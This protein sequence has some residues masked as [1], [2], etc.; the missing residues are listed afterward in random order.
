MKLFKKLYYRAAFAWLFLVKK[1]QQNKDIDNKAGLITLNSLSNAQ[2]QHIPKIIWMYWEGSQSGLLK[3][4]I[5]RIRDLHP[6]YQ[7]YL[8]DPENVKE[9]SQLDFSDPIIE[10]ATPQQRADLIRFDL[11]YRYGGIW[12]DA[13]ILVYEKLDW[14]DDLVQQ[15]QTQSFSYYRAKNTINLN[16]PVIENWLLASV[17]NNAFFRHWLD[18]LYQALKIGYKKYI[19][20]LKKNS[21]SVEIFQEIGRLEYLIAYVVCQ[22]VMREY[23]I[24]MVLIDCDK[25]AFFYQVSNQWMKEKV[26]IDMGIHFAPKQKPKLIKL[27]GKER[28]YL[29]YYY[30][31]GN[32]LPES[33]IDI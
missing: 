29:E 16:Y 1:R 24:S 27:A 7:V 20:E 13:S 5:Q 19:A 25:N 8:L 15:T 9:Y 31:T 21:H 33:L 4:C 32:Y 11:I 22:Q 26:L 30:M 3:A 18:G 6:D 28:K 10:H 2:L 12:L 14:I 23:Q 17:A